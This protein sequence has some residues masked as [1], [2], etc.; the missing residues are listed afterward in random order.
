[1]EAPEQFRRLV[2]RSGAVIG[3]HAACFGR[4]SASVWCKSDVDALAITSRVFYELIVLA[5][6]PETHEWPRQPD[7][8]T[9]GADR[10]LAAC[11]DELEGA[12]VLEMLQA[13]VEALL[14]GEC[15]PDE[16]AARSVALQCALQSLV[17]AGL[18][19]APFGSGWPTRTLPPTLT[20]GELPLPALALTRLACPWRRSPPWAVS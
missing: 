6:R 8:A 5:P 20:L 2:E 15:E 3:E 14:K 16:L 1:M 13:R 9:A 10:L 4:A 12:Q 7:S 17:G 19:S 11:R 18:V